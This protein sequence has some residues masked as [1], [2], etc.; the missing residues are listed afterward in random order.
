MKKK[1][2]TTTIIMLFTTWFCT[3]YSQVD[4][5]KEKARDKKES[6]RE[7]QNSGDRHSRRSHHHDNDNNDLAGCFGDIIWFILYKSFE[8]LQTAAL[9]QKADYPYITSAESKLWAGYSPNYSA[10]IFSPELKGNW[11]IFSTDFRF[12]SLHDNTGSLNNF[13]WQIIKLNIPVK[14][15]KAS[16][17]IGFTQLLDP[18]V[19]YFE[20]TFG[21]ELRLFKEKAVFSGEYRDS[22]IATGDH[23]RREVSVQ[24][25][26]EIIKTGNFHFSPF[27]GFRYQ[28]YFN[29]FDYYYLNTGL[30]VRFY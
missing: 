5:I 22:P 6:D 19:S 16:A 25:D 23:F 20:Y 26:Y 30:V 17:G 2:I 1:I 11:G 12:V 4:D 21:M 15:F 9:S 13:E 14:T 29:E 18:K 3:L 28:Q 27:V 24:T 8:G 7:E 10:L